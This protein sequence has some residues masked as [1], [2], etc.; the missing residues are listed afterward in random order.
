MLCSSAKIL[1]HIIFKHL[2]VFVESSNIV[3]PH[4]HGFRTGFSTITQLV[5]TIHNFPAVVDMHGQIDIIRFR[6]SLQSC[7][8]PEITA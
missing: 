6:K 8:S 2:A 7:E 4:Q 5:E 1:E 3:T